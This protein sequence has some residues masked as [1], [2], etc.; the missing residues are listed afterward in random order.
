ME[1]KW[2]QN[3]SLEA[4]GRLLGGSWPQMAAQD[5]RWNRSWWPFG[6]V[7]ASVGPLLLRLG[8]LLA[9]FGAVL[10]LQGGF[11]APFW[12]ALGLDFG[13]PAANCDFSEN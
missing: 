13:P 1:P 12:E 7:L 11:W 3:G 4:S 2:L 10:G 6:A 8:R 9:P 5:P